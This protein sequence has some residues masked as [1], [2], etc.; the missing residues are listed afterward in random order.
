MVNLFAHRYYLL[1]PSCL[2][3]LQQILSDLFG[4]AGLPHVDQPGAAALL[5]PGGRPGVR[6]GCEAILDPG[7]RTGPLG[8]TAAHR[9]HFPIALWPFVG[10]WLDQR[11]WAKPPS[12][13]RVDV[14]Q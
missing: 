1:T 3:P 11:A 7:D 13:R 14:H 8:E 6:G 5:E 9:Q 12:M 2:S 10:R 4:E